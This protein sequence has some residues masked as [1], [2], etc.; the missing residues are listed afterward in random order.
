MQGVARRAKNRREVT[1]S[2]FESYLSLFL[3]CVITYALHYYCR[4][5][6]VKD[7]QERSQSQKNTKKRKYK[8]PKL[9]YHAFF[10][11]GFF[12]S[13]QTPILILSR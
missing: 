3:L 13:P 11:I 1:S 5:D 7:K 10:A 6:A 9:H 4:A 2:S 8:E 12:I